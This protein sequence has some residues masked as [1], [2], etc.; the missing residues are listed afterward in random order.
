M[1]GK[2]KVYTVELSF[3]N[4]KEG[5]VMILPINPQSMEVSESGNGS[6]YDVMGLGE[7]NV[8]KDRQLTEYSFSSI[9]PA[10]HYPFMHSETFLQ[11]I[12]YIK[13]I[14][15]WMTTKRPIRFIFISNT[16]DIN[17]AASIESFDWKEVAGSGGDIS[18]SLK[19]KKYVFYAARKI[20]QAQDTSRKVVQTKDNKARP[21]DSQSPR[22]YTLV[23]GDTLWKV[24][25]MKL[26]N[27]DRWKEI[28]QL[29][30]ITDAQ[31]KKLPI[32]KVLKLP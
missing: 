23:K 12:Q 25:K 20:K 15:K 17:T 27:G 6:S 31:I 4:R 14:E 10:R 2:M 21:N 9:F 5:E 28:Q 7:I 18:F 16:Y 8:I 29:N 24:A 1:D 26:G 3:D 19:L 22:T 13:K 11:P 32:G 30:G